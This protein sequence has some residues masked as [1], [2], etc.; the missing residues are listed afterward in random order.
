M[1]QIDV[2][3][4]II[5]LNGDQNVTGFSRFD[6]RL[7]PVLLMRALE[8]R[9]AGQMKTEAGVPGRAEGGAV[10]WVGELGG[11]RGRA[12]MGLDG[13]DQQQRGAAR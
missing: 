8:E 1:G 10:A 13:V 3:R 6:G 11:R 7:F 5:M 2:K 9:R 12:G 4:G